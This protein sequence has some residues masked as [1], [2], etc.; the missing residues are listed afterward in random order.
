MVKMIYSYLLDTAKSPIAGKSMKV[1]L[2][3]EAR[4][5]DLAEFRSDTAAIIGILERYIYIFALMFAQPTLIT[6]ILILKAFFGWTDRAGK[7]TA[8]P[9]G[10]IGTVAL[11][12]TYV[13]GNLLSVLLAILLG[14]VGLYLFPGL[15]IKVGLKCTI[16]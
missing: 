7:E 6:G 2:E 12:H 8:V 3:E 5:R 16:C 14:L 15:L 10:M 13:I 9:Q 4:D 11:Y 1:W